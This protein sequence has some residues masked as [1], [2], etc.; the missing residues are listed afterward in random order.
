MFDYCLYLFWKL[1]NS[2][3]NPMDETKDF[4][5]SVILRLMEALKNTGIFTKNQFE[6]LKNI[7]LTSEYNI[8]EKSASKEEYLYNINAQLNKIYGNKHWETPNS[9][10]ASQEGNKW[11]PAE[12]SVGST[13]THYSYG[14]D[15]SINGLQNHNERKRNNVP[16]KFES[17]DKHSPYADN[18]IEHR[19]NHRPPFDDYNKD[20]RHNRNLKE[21]MNDYESLIGTNQHKNA[22]I[23]SQWKIPMKEEGG[24]HGSRDEMLRYSMSQH[25]DNGAY[26]AGYSD[27]SMRYGGSSIRSQAN[28]IQDYTSQNRRGRKPGDTNK[29]QLIKDTVVN[30]VPRY[31]KGE[32]GDFIQRTEREYLD[33]DRYPMTEN[34]GYS[35]NYIIHENGELFKG[36][37]KIGTNGF[38][39]MYRMEDTTKRIKEVDYRKMMETGEKVVDKGIDRGMQKAVYKGGDKEIQTVVY[40][41]V[42]IKVGDKYNIHSLESNEPNTFY[43]SEASLTRAKYN[44]KTEMKQSSNFY[45]GDSVFYNTPIQAKKVVKVE[46]DASTVTSPVIP[47]SATNNFQ[48]E[49]SGNLKESSFIH[50]SPVAD[51]EKEADS[52]TEESSGAADETTVSP[53]V[54]MCVSTRSSRFASDPAF[55]TLIDSPLQINLIDSK[56]MAQTQVEIPEDLKAFLFTNSLSVINPKNKRRW[57]SLF[58]TLVSSNTTQIDESQSLIQLL[59][60][61]S[62]NMDF[63]FLS[64]EF[65]SKSI[66]KLESLI[67][68]EKVKIIQEE[69]T[70]AFNKCVIRFKKTKSNK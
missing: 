26:G 34:N 23:S 56:P 32:N 35:K 44:P 30:K 39:P 4:R 28:E 69:T 5:R 38:N 45:C 68:C 24:W 65:L 19:F 27:A 18:Y 57:A 67:R 58:K 43:K 47:L 21:P 63:V 49:P 40:K 64:E 10:S 66:T 42:D 48:C 62:K 2:K 16:G 54:N 6:D 60:M 41:E 15:S 3:Q 36:G 8:F 29:K 31:P 1:I 55:R 13:A 70:E 25:G 61:Q 17:V 33:G 11:K 46:E 7:A 51:S 59:E 22:E 9:S 52:G 37:D 12:Y 50:D 20:P 53:L 14:Y